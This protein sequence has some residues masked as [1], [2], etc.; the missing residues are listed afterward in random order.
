M[1]HV[2][3]V[4]PPDQTALLTDRLAGRTEVL[5]LV[6]VPAVAR[7]PRG[8]AVQFDVLHRAANSVLAD[9]RA[10]GLDRESS[11]MI[12]AVE[13]TLVDETR[14]QAWRRFHRG[15]QTPVWELVEARI[16]DDAT[17]P[18]SFFVLLVLA[19][20]I[21]ACGIL[22]NSQILIVGAMVVGPEFGAIISVALGLERHDGLPVRRGLLALL[23]GFLLA[24]GFTLAF[25]VCIR[26]LG[27][28][29]EQYLHGVRP[30]SDFINSPNLFSV[31]VAVLAGIAGVVSLTLAKTG[32][33]IGVFIS[34]TTIPAAADVGVSLAFSSWPEARG[35]AIQLLLNVG[36]LITIGAFG[37]RA[38]R[39]IWSRWL[40]PA[41]A[42][43]ADGGHAAS[44][45]S[46][47]QLE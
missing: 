37:L 19:G 24:I 40:R 18:P 45:G 28:A 42:G 21:G 39:L 8:D 27:R 32:A 35:S 38:Q 34:V 29:P 22:T 6:V 2:R 11:I 41:S 47:H 12:N 14:L 36:V 10:T 4:C 16:A 30:V 13:A 43:P 44:A 46:G 15:E 25:A 33:L 7:H 20:L 9:L 26:S 5:N 3:V 1:L 17:Y 31:I 23:A